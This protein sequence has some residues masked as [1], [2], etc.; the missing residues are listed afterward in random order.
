MDRPASSSFLPSTKPTRHRWRAED[1]YA[2]VRPDMGHWEGHGR[3]G[4]HATGGAADGHAEACRD[5]NAAGGRA[6]CPVAQEKGG[7][8]DRPYARR[9]R[10]RLGGLA[11]SPSPGSC[12]RPSEPRQTR[13]PFPICRFRLSR[14]CR[15]CNR[16][17]QD[18]GGNKGYVGLPLQENPPTLFR[19]VL[20]S[21]MPESRPGKYLLKPGTVW[22]KHCR[23][24][25]GPFFFCCFYASN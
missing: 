1:V 10:P 7:P 20:Y 15:A 14:S 2:A 23:V 9:S 16:V 8:T 18:R 25:E 4:R 3:T 19:H 17:R 6:V 12:L 13:A 22:L 21:Q 11:C 24:I 5:G